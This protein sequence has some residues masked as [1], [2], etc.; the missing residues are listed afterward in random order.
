MVLCFLAKD[1]KTLITCFSLHGEHW[2]LHLHYAISFVGAMK[3]GMNCLFAKLAQI[4]K[5][6]LWYFVLSSTF[7]SK[8]VQQKYRFLLIWKA[9][10]TPEMPESQMDQF[11][12]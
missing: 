8:Y 11:M 5:C 2:K 9:L 1:F 12:L 6:T 4:Y 7:L 3:F 10:E